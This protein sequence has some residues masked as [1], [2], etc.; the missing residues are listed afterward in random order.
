MA[1]NVLPA[2]KVLKW[3]VKHAM[4]ENYA[5][6][7]LGFAAVD[8]YISD[9]LAF[10]TEHGIAAPTLGS[11]APPG[12]A[13]RYALRF[14]LGKC[15]RKAIPKSKERGGGSRRYACTSVH[16]RYDPCA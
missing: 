12:G 2:G 7:S 15:M 11:I 9:A 3:H 1:R 13:T 8:K 14:K 6:G 10:V 4:P 16:P 5:E